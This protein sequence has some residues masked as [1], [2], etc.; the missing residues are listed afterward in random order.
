MCELNTS[1]RACGDE[2]WKRIQE[3]ARYNYRHLQNSPHLI[4]EFVQ[5]VSDHCTFVSDWT[6]PK[7]THDTFRVYSRKVPVREAAKQYI[8]RV[9]RQ[10]DHSQICERVAKDVEKN[11]YSHCEWQPAQSS[12]VEE[13]DQKLKEP[14]TLL[15]FAGA[16]FE[17]TYNKEGSFSQ[18]Q[19]ALL[20]T[21]PAQR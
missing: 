20:Y 11:R 19:L 14:H 15:F 7:I 1:V 5:L 2:N 13:L 18:S 17:C 8:D 10:I 4:D 6:D 3:I 12:T 21:L 9:R 16:I